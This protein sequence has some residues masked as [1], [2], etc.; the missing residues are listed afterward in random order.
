MPKNQG[1]GEDR[2][3]VKFRFIEV[4][5][6]GAN[7]ALENSIRHFVTAMHD[8]NG[9]PPKPVTKTLPAKQTKELPPA[10]DHEDRDEQDIEHEG[11]EVFEAAMPTPKGC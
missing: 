10:T 2:A 4:E 6:E 3:K 1:S 5:L 8:R 7:S 9:A 11:G